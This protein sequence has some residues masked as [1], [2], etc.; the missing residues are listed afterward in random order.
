MKTYILVGIVVL[1][2]ISC[3]SSA[4]GT[5]GSNGADGAIGP[6]GP[7]G[8]AGINGH[9]GTNGTNGATG[10]SPYSVMVLRKEQTQTGPTS[11]PTCPNDWTQVT[12][13]HKEYYG[14]GYNNY[15]QCLN[16]TKA[17]TVLYFNTVLPATTDGYPDTC[18]DGFTD[19]YNTW[20]YVGNPNSLVYQRV[21]YE[22]H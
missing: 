17:C 3:G 13:L 8:P 18:P 2:L 7:Q 9:D 10:A 15:V 19:V 20:V 16:T 5:A 4:S 6:T 14:G 21:C 12:V 1:T 22:C 11:N